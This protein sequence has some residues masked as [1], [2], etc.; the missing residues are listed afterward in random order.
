M[1]SEMALQL[2]AFGTSS[3]LMEHSLISTLDPYW[4]GWQ[5][6]FRIIKLFLWVGWIDC[7]FLELSLST[8]E[9]TITYLLLKASHGVLTK[10]LRS[11]TVGQ[12]NIL[13]LQKLLLARYKVLCA[14]PSIASSWLCLSTNGSIRNEEDFVAARGLVHDQNGGWIIGFCKYLENC[15]VTEAE[16]WG[17]LDESRLILCKSFERVSIQMDSLK[18]LMPSEMVL[19]KTLILL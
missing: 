9:R 3:F 4:N 18:A 16:L 19:L 15:T 12:D 6:T 8:F 7:A 11:P 5:K 2:G 10:S 14:S 17:I 1:F 13:Q